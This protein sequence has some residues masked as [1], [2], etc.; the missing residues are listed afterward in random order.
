MHICSNKYYQIV[1]QRQKK[2][3][4]LAP[5]L[6]QAEALMQYSNMCPYAVENRDRNV[7]SS[8]CI[9]LIYSALISCNLAIRI[10]L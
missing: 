7:R 4:L 9:F 1:L 2:K 8:I 10:F 5:D 6:L 3:A